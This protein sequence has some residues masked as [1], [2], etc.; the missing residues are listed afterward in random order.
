M[1]KLYIGG[2]VVVKDSVMDHIMAG[3]LRKL[4][5]WDSPR[6]VE[7]HN[8]SVRP[9]WLDANFPEL[10]GAKKK[11]I[12]W[13]QQCD[14]CKPKWLKELSTMGVD[15]FW[16]TMLTSEARCSRMHSTRNGEF[17]VNCWLKEQG[18]M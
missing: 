7:P 9:L 18:S 1:P 6:S 15:D 17:K 5:I 13:G 2:H 4:N 14:S 8:Q 3:P 10:V 12:S 16:P 11:L